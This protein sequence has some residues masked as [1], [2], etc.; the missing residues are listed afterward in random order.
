MDNK[1]RNYVKK[2]KYKPFK[3]Q[4]ELDY[5]EMKTDVNHVVSVVAKVTKNLNNDINKAVRY[6]MQYVK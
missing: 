3:E 4:T 1:F 6:A 5:H 2:D